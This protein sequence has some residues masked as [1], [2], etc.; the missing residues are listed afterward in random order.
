M[1]LFRMNRWP[2]A[3][4]MAAASL[5]ASQAAA[6]DAGL[7]ITVTTPTAESGGVYVA[8][9]ESGETFPGGEAAYGT[10]SSPADSQARLS[11]GPLP[12][13]RYAVAAFQDLNANGKLDTNLA[14]VPTE[15]FGFSRNARGA[16]GPPDFADAAVSVPDVRRVE[17]HLLD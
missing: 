1:N 16:M 13:G 17:I 11:V 3:A 9:H 10:R 4:G 5:A 7:D 12:P 15:P 2:A 14:G 6:S 8:V